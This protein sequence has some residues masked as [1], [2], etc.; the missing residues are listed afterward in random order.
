MP[1]VTTVHAERL[2]YVRRSRGPGG[3][4][5]VLFIH[6]AGGNA[7]LWGRVL[8]ALPGVDAIA[9]DLPGHGRSAGPGY[10]TIA[11]YAAT[12]LA[13]AD[14]LALEA[15][16]VAGHSMGGAI[17]LELALHAPARVVGLALISTT[18]RLA[19]APALLQQLVDDPAQARQWIVDIGYGP[20]IPAAVRQLGA[21]QLAAVAPAVLHGD[22]LACNRYDARARLPEVRCPALVLCG[23]EDRLTPPKYVRALQEGLPAARLELV[24]GA[25]HMLP[26]E[27]PEA[28]AA[29]ITRFLAALA[30]SPGA[31]NQSPD[32]AGPHRSEH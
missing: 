18:A 19:V 6:G 30:S 4:P 31:P 29:A 8:N 7:L 25:G 28:V 3:P 15:L 24:A 16:V 9:L 11:D 14:A 27:R 2:Y 17:A 22:F 1:Y 10:S 13:A 20:G 12:A 5:A 21:R 32:Q 23:T 26:L